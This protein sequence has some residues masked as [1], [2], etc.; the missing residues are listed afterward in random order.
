[1]LHWLALTLSTLLLGLQRIIPYSCDIPLVNQNFRNIAE[2]IVSLP[3]EATATA[4]WDTTTATV[5]ATDDETGD[6]ISVQLPRTTPGDPNVRSAGKILYFINR[7]G[8]NVSMGA[9]MDDKIGT[10]KDWTGSV[11]NIPG[12]WALADGSANSSPGSGYDYTGRFR[13]GHDTT[14]GTENAAAVTSTNNANISSAASGGGHTPVT[15]SDGGHTP[16]TQ[17]AGA[18]THTA[19]TGAATPS[20]T[21]DVSGVLV[22]NLAGSK[23]RTARTQ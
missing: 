18:H 15:Q 16:V 7:L 3:R 23:P 22:D 20:T 14:A 9:H 19:A 1:M 10:V 12:G 5:A 11:A 8:N 17:S 2:A 21:V 4:N 13:L 6:A